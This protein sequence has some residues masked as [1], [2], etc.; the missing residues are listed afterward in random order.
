MLD[1]SPKTE[2]K[3]QELAI[4]DKTKVMISEE[5][6]E[7]VGKLKVTEDLVRNLAYFPSRERQNL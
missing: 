4:S 7:R 5:L 1:G 2:N 3:T 6:A